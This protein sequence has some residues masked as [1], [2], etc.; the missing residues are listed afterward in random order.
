MPITFEKLASPTLRGRIAEQMREAILDGRLAEGER[1]VERKLASEF[2]ASLT[3]VREALIELE[4]DGFIEKLPNSTTHVIRLSEEDADKILSVR[5]VLE[6]Y[7]I[8]EVAKSASEAEIEALMA[9][10]RDILE[11]AE[12]GEVGRCLQKDLAFHT[13]LWEITGNEHLAAS[14][15]RVV[16]PFYTFY[17]LRMRRG[18][19]NDLRE[20]AEAYLLVMSALHARDSKGASK[21][22]TYALR[23][24][25]E[26]ARS[27]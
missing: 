17:S 11:A 9:L 8:A 7:A 25:M 27:V 12:R 1:I 16:L 2:G 15:R 18:S 23:K 4:T 6:G 5:T 10:V 24:W 21:A 13:A 19:L 20:C 26:K 22:L 14:L 3:A